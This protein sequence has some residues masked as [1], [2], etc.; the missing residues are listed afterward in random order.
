MTCTQTSSIED[1]AQGWWEPWIVAGGEEVP[2]GQEAI[3][4]RRRESQGSVLVKY[5]WVC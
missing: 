1:K 2:T 5:L 4:G 3:D